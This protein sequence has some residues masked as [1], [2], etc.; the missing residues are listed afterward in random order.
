VKDFSS[1][2]YVPPHRKHIKGKGNIFCKN[3]NHVYAE[4]A[5]QHSNKRSLPTCHHWSHPTQ[6]SIAPSSEEEGSEEVAY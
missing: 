3:A 5:K 2:K 6:M 4:K 1:S